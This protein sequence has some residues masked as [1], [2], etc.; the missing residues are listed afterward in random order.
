MADLEGKLRELAKRTKDA[1][2]RQK[3]NTGKM[4]EVNIA[5]REAAALGRAEGLE[6]A[7]KFA[8]DAHETINFFGPTSLIGAGIARAIRA[9]KESRD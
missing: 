7:A 8:E 3:F 9:L 1:M 4:A 6:E 2:A 5:L